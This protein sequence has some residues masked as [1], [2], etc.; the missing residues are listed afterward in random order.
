MVVY[1]IIYICIYG[2]R[3]LSVLIILHTSYNLSSQHSYKVPVS[4]SNPNLST[5]SLFVT[6][7]VTEIR[8]VLMSRV[9]C[10]CKHRIHGWFNKFYLCLK[11]KLESLA[12]SKMYGLSTNSIQ[13]PEVGVHRI[14]YLESSEVIGYLKLKAHPPSQFS[15]YQKVQGLLNLLA[16]SCVDW[17]NSTIFHHPHHH[18]KKFSFYLFVFSISWVCFV[19]FMMFMNHSSASSVFFLC[20]FLF[21]PF[22]LF[23]IS[24]FCWGM[25]CYG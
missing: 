19:L 21:H 10:L 17:E 6:K 8:L 13:S 3:V 23:Y 18:H 7:S 15:L 22:F 11:L 16:D 9:K 14:D 24:A 25:A 12:Q 4:L 20:C 5:I 2:N 1:Y